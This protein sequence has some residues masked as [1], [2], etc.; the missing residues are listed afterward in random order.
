MIAWGNNLRL[1]IMNAD[2]AGR[3]MIT[4][5][6]DPSWSVNDILVFSHANQNYSREVLYTY[7]LEGK[8]ITQ[9]TK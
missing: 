6:N 9:I 2:G 5:G 8:T 7:D 3:H 1:M 4:Y